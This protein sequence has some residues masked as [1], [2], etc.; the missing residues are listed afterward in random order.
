MFLDHSLLRL[1]QEEQQSRAAQAQAELLR[2]RLRLQHCC[3][4]P[5]QRSREP[6]ST[7]KRRRDFLPPQASLQSARFAGDVLARPVFSAAA[8]EQLQEPALFELCRTQNPRLILPR[9]SQIESLV[10]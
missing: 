8:Y 6:S 7:R 5:T 4:P 3:G 1:D 2:S 10:R 9:R